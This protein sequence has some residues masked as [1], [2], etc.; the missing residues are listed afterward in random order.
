M[1][2]LT[3]DKSFK[4]KLRRINIKVSLSCLLLVLEVCNVLSTFRKSF[5][6]NLLVVLPLTLNHFFKVKLWPLNI[7]VHVT[8]A[9][10]SNMLP[11]SCVLYYVLSC[12][13]SID[14]LLEMKSCR[15]YVTYI[16]IT[17]FLMSLCGGY[18]PAS[19]HRCE[20]T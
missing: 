17:N 1:S 15:S 10:P 9:A 3:L 11:L 14:S 20:H 18:N 12:V 7:K 5:A 8:L 2:D 16:S 13:Q 19:G 6:K 4:V